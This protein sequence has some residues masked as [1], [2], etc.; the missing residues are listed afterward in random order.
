[1]LNV[2]ARQPGGSERIKD[3]VWSKEPHAVGKSSEFTLALTDG[4]AWTW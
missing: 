2:A 3:A 4:A 1:M